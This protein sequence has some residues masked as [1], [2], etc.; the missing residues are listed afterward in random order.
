MF[1]LLP[2]VSKVRQDML[3][4]RNISANNVNIRSLQVRIRKISTTKI[5]SSSHN[6]LFGKKPKLLDAYDLFNL[7]I[8]RQIW[9]LKKDTR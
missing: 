3:F 5:Y 2:N 4:F 8:V 6:S 1:F 9:N 7:K